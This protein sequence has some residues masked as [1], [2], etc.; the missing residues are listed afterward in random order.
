MRSR[1]IQSLLDLNRQFYHASAAS[2]AATRRRIQPGVRKVLESLPARIRW[3]DLGCGSG[4]LAAAWAAS[5]RT[6]LYLGLDSSPGLLEEA[7]RTAADLPPDPGR[8]IRFNLADLSAP[9]WDAPLAAGSFDLVTAFAVLHHLPGTDLRL[10]IL[11]K[12]RALLAPGGR[13]IH[14]EW[15]FHHS[16]RLL[17]R[18]LPWETLPEIDPADLDPG[19]TLLDWRAPGS[20]PALRY[21]HLFTEAELSALAAQTA[22]RVVETFISDGQNHRLALYQSWEKIA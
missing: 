13:F 11:R 10:E 16:P 22:F 12:V 3:L 1:T 18:V 6:G 9:A 5:G 20:P 15:Q 17:A 4:A 7:R 21:V 14:S 8:E 19:D 2:F